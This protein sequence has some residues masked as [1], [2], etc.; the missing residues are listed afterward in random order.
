MLCQGG[1][2][3]F[4]V[5]GMALGLGVIAPGVGHFMLLVVGLS[6]LVTPPA[7]LLGRRLG[8]AI[9]ARLGSKVA[10]PEDPLHEL[11]GHVIIAGYGRVGQLVGEMLTAQGVPHVA[12]ESD[13][14]IVAR[15]RARGAPVHFG[16]A[17]RPEL[18]RRFHLERAVAVVLTMDHTAAAVHA[19][20]GVRLTAPKVRIAARARDENHAGALRAAGASVVI[21]ETLESG[22]QL[23]GSVLDTLGVSAEVASRLLDHERQRRAGTFREA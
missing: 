6:M 2:F 9:D 7:T 15:L 3:A 14:K 4:I 10:T 8:D 13:A 12:I 19:V 11:A 16:D 18:L 17:S 21:Q 1:E 20:K 23:A 22:L 5:I